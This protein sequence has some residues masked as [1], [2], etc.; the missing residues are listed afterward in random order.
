MPP[1]MQ[2]GNR[3]PPSA[4][5]AE[6]T[7]DSDDPVLRTGYMIAVS[8]TV[9]EKTEVE[10]MVVQV[11]DQNEVALPLI[12]KVNCKD[13]TLDAFRSHLTTRYSVYY[14]NPEVT[15]S[16]VVTEM[17][18][19]PWGA[20]LVQG[21]VMHEGW[22]NIPATRDLTVTRAIQL[23]GGFG[24]SASKDDVVVHRTN[25]DGTKQRIKVDIRSIGR[26]GNLEN[27]ILLQSGDVINVYEKNF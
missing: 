6:N 18:A 27:D 24:P 21:R 20:V 9:G 19:S 23:A 26:K 8:V 11:S 22:V 15:A 2:G 17:G 16:F 13:M 1:G 12:G 25:P 3:T 10:P 4:E 5:A 14:V 7:P